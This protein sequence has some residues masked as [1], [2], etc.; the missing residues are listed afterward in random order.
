[1][2]YSKIFKTFKTDNDIYTL[3]SMAKLFEK[4]KYTT[5]Q[6]ELCVKFLNWYY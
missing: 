4:N 6:D 1:M 2:N 3:N 5:L